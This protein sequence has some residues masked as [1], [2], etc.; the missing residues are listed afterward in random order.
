MSTT[1]KGKRQADKSGNGGSTPVKSIAAPSQQSAAAPSPF[2]PI[3]DYAFLSDCHTG[4][5]VAPDGTID[6]LCIPRFDSPSVFGSLLDRGAGAFRLGPFGINVPSGRTWE[7]GTNTLV[8]AWKTPSGWAIVHDALTMGPRRGE[9]TIT[10]HTRPPTDE[11]ADHVLVRT[12]SASRAASRSSSCA[13]RASTTAV[14][15]PS[16]RWSRI[17]IG[18]MRPAPARRCVCRR[19]C[20]SG[21]RPIT[22]AP[23]T[24]STR[25]R[26]SSVRCRG[27]TMRRSRAPSKKPMPSSSRRPGSGATGCPGPESPTTSSA[28]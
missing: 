19:T 7:P 3:A 6:W 23:G 17:A 8:T 10:P 26:S 24:C 27:M 2:T 16:G 25:A 15:W 22:S 20:C 1:I 5:L 13:S 18:P 4:A 11:D 12:V 28:R 9:D 21:S 14:P